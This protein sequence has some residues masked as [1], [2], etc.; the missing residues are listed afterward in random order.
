MTK[1]LP[2]LARVVE[3]EVAEVVASATSEAVA[4]DALFARL[5][6]DASAPEVAEVATPEAPE[7]AAQAPSAAV[8]EE[9]EPEPEPEPVVPEVADDDEGV[10][11]ERDGVLAPLLRDAVKRAKRGLQDDQN[12]VLDRLRTAKG[13]PDAEVVLGDAAAGAAAWVERLREPIAAAYVGAHTT[14]STEP[15]PAVPPEFEEPEGTQLRPFG[16]GSTTA[17]NVR[18]NDGNV[19]TDLGPISK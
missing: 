10:R 12:E 8:A 6:A 16:F 15:A 5:R 4:V 19:I 9:P 18:W 1:L 11:A 17:M 13:R 3:V 14:H 2:L 7:P